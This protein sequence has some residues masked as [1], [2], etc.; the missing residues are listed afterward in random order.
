[1]T[2]G[3]ASDN[4]TRLFARRC[5]QVLAELCILTAEPRRRLAR[6]V[7]RPHLEG[8]VRIQQLTRGNRLDQ[9][10]RNCIVGK[11]IAQARDL[12]GVH[13][14]A[15]SPIRGNAGNTL[16]RSRTRCRLTDV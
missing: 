3:M 14:L 7:H 16:R 5:A 2:G 10:L 15:D 11:Q 6:I 9:R 12:G 1:M 13:P 8:V 4:C